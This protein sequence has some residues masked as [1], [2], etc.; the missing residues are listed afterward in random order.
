MPVRTTFSALQWAELAPV[1]ASLTERGPGGKDDRLFIE[2]VVWILRTGAPWRDVPAV[3]G[4]WNTLYRRFRRWAEA[5]RWERLRRALL[6]RASDT[7]DA[8]MLID[9]TIVKAHAHAAG[10][11]RKGGSAPAQALGRSR[12]G[13]TTKLHAVVSEAGQLHEY[14]LTGGQVNDV[15]EAP[16]LVSGLRAR[17]V[18]GDRAYDSDAF[19]ALL[20][21]RGT[22]AVVPSRARRRQPRL[23]DAEAY[24]ARNVIERWFGRLKQYRRIATR[25]DKTSRSY[26]SLVAAAASCMAISGWAA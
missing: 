1:V 10:A 15:T 16:A 3:F 20:E 23:L 12:G 8:L 18:V 11:R 25:Y 22:Q 9:S 21:Q 4:R 2:G 6:R 17:A 5:D 24:R 13:L 26:A 7:H 14:V 19:I